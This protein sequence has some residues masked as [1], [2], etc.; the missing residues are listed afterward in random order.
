[1]LRWEI[2]I[3]PV[4]ETQCAHPAAAFTIEASIGKGKGSGVSLTVKIQ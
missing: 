1:M 2:K 3:V 4:A